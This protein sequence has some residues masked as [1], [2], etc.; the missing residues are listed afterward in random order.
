MTSTLLVAVCLLA[1]LT[2]GNL[3]LLFAV[4]R[5]L[6][7]VQELAVPSMPVPAV[8]TIVEPFNVETIDGREIAVNEVTSG[9][10]LLAFLSNTCPA[11]K[12]MAPQIAS[13]AL[14]VEPPVVL[15]VAGSRQESSALLQSLSGLDRVAVISGD[16]PAAEAAGRIQAFP[17]LLA[18]SGGKIA[19]SGTSLDK[20]LPALTGRRKEP[21]S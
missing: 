9:P 10:F 18:V 1:I 3:L 19:A 12:T 5:R 20:V 4:I 15:V 2:F 8:G 6:R 7:A 13:L 17:I 21:V 14:S 16:H 11:C